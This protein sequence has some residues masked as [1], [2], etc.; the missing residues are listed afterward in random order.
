MTSRATTAGTAERYRPEI[1][2][3]RAIAVLSVI[4][5]HASATILPGGFLG[6]DVFFVISGYLITRHIYSDLEAGRFALSRFYLKR[7]R[8]IAPA[9][10]LVCA[11]T[12]PFAI[13]LMLPD[14]LQNYGQSL[15]ASVASV[16]NVLLWLTT[17]YF[18]LATAF[19]PLVHSWSLGI[20][21]QYY[22]LVPLLLALAWR[23]AGRAGVTGVLLVGSIG[24]LV[25]M[26]LWRRAD[27]SGNF[28]L[29]PSRFWELGLGGLA[30]LYK[31]RCSRAIPAHVRAGI[32]AASLALIVLPM[33]VFA[34]DMN[35]PSLWTLAPVAGTAGLLVFCD[36]DGVGRVLVLPPLVG[37]GLVSYSAYLF[38]QPVF[39]FLRIGQLQEVST[40]QLYAASAGVLM[41]A[42][43]S[44]RFVEAP[45]RNPERIPTRR[46]LAITGG[47]AVALMAAGL[48]LHVTAGLPARFPELNRS[49]PTFGAEAFARYV[50]GPYVYEGRPLDPAQRDSNL[51]IL[52]N[53][54]AR[55]FINMGRETGSFGG[56]TVSYDSREFCQRGQGEILARAAAAGAVVIASDE[57]GELASCYRDLIARLQAAGVAHIAVIG[58]KNFGSNNN[59]VMRLPE[60]A[61]RGLRV[62][63][64]RQSLADNRAAARVLGPYYVDIFGLLDDGAGT[65]PVFTP[66][67]DFISQD[68][69]HLTRPGARYVG[70]LV[71]ATPQLSWLRRLPG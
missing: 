47:G 55:D 69:L 68:R 46:L 48:A 57:V 23:V 39:A 42:Y 51:L 50:D 1:D 34:E 56:W 38:H 2:G 54:F 45:F 11:L 63:P 4:A 41:L 43:L 10:L 66:E 3:L 8:R 33:L 36:R 9:L 32:A 16:N 35:L 28:Y 24:S 22:V 12:V 20:E 44:W 25:A 17:D 30:G 19:K 67:S 71:F 60:S 31:E 70:N 40:W 7:V 26:E 13:W 14:D 15:F 52:G 37:V 64:V 27:P 21:E 58:T 59:A 49:D 65:V 6:V 61:R 62:P 5:Y 53:S 29:L 18:S